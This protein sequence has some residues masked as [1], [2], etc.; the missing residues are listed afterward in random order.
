MEKNTQQG[1]KEEKMFY[2]VYT[3]NQLLN[4]YHPFCFMEIQFTYNLAMQ[5]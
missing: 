3:K 1:K 2:L 4:L 5:Q